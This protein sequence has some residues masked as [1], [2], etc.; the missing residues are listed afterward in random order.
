MNAHARLFY[1]SLSASRIRK[2]THRYHTNHTIL[3]RVARSPSSRPRLAA[4]LSVFVGAGHCDI[5]DTHLWTALPTSCKARKAKYNLS[6]NPPSRN[7]LVG[8]I[9]VTVRRSHAGLNF[10]KFRNY[11]AYLQI[12]RQCLGGA[13]SEMSPTYR[14]HDNLCATLLHKSRGNAPGFPTHHYCLFFFSLHAKPA[15]L[16]VTAVVGAAREGAACARYGKQQNTDCCLLC[17]CADDGAVAVFCDTRIYQ[18]YQHDEHTKL[19]TAVFVP[20][21]VQPRTEQRPCE[22]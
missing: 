14:K 11:A 10:P 8:S 22:W 13:T 17:A 15:E 16:G 18:S 3:T 12:W 2:T 5:S 19:S 4:A 6:T 21:D 9:N 20:S 1:Y 7:S